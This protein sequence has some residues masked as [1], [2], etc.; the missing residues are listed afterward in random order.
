MNLNSCSSKLS[1]FLLASLMF[2]SGIF[3]I[4]NSTAGLVSGIWLLFLGEWKFVLG[5]LVSASISPFL[6]SLL[7]MPTLAIAA[8]GAWLI[9][10]KLNFI[11]FP[12]VFLGAICYQLVIVIW[13]G[14]VLYFSLMFA[15][16]TDSHIPT[17]IFS[18]GIAIAPLSYFASKE[19]TSEG[20][21]AVVTASFAYLLII[22][23]VLIFNDVIWGV[24]HLGELQFYI[25]GIILSAQLIY[26]FLQK[27]KS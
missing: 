8:F 20:N 24:K 11:G 15:I 2:L 17:L 14:T 6:L 4:F 23:K 19:K 26:F 3:I 9:Q 13:L 10:K 5:G 18:Y 16:V 21:L 7:L 12:I 22:F 1:S 27:N 25:L